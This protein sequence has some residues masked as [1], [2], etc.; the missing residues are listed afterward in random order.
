[1]IRLYILFRDSAG[2]DT[3]TPYRVVCKDWE[4]RNK[5][6]E[7]VILFS[8]TERKMPTRRPTTRQ[9]NDYQSP[10]LHRMTGKRCLPPIQPFWLVDSS[11]AN[12]SDFSL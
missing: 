5:Q 1:M 7:Q 12:R 2:V 8:Q 10:L 4:G 6:R 9:K 11:S 3:L